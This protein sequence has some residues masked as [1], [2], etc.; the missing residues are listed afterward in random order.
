M[1]ANIVEKT[2]D[3][4]LVQYTDRFF[5]AV[6]AETPEI[7][8]AL[9]GKY[10]LMVLVA[11]DV[12]A[13]EAEMDAFETG[14]EGLAGVTKAFVLIGPARIPLDRVPTGHDLFISVEAGFDI[15]PEAV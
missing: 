13:S 1:R 4:V 12:E 2:E 8:P 14:I 3:E 10:A 6:H 9:T 15:R 11:A 7:L 5:R